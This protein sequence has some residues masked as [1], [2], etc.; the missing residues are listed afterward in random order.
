MQLTLGVRFDARSVHP[1]LE[2]KDTA[3]LK[4]DMTEDVKKQVEG[5]LKD[6]QF[7][8]PDGVSVTLNGVWPDTYEKILDEVRLILRTPKGMSITEH[9]Q[10]VMKERR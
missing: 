4:E 5:L 6:A 2:L 7:T 3:S 8:G 1:S 10:A 9:A